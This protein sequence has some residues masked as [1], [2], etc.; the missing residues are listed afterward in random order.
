MLYAGVGLAVM[1]AVSMMSARTI[2]RLALVLFI[3]SLAAWWFAKR[4][5][6]L[7]E[8]YTVPV[9]SGIIAGESLMGVLIAGLTVAK[10]LK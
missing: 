6:Q 3:G 2:R 10:I 1:L 4:K 8:Q 9:A 7:A 5:P